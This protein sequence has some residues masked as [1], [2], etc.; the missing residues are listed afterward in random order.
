MAVATRVDAAT[1]YA[2]DVTEGRI[3]A[4]R[5]VRLACQRHLRDL[6]D[7]HLRG[8]HFDA[9]EAEWA[10]EFYERYLI[11]KDGQFSGRPFKLEPSQRFITGCIFGWK[12]ADGTRRFRMVYIEQGKGN[13]KTPWLA[14]T[15]LKLLVADRE[16]GAEIY[17][18]AVTR[19]QAGILFKDATEMVKRSPALSSKLTL[20]VGNIANPALGGFFRPV[21]HEAKSLDGKR[22][23]GGLIDELHEHQSGEAVDKIRMGTKARRQPLIIEITNSGF[24]TSSICWEHHDYSEKVLEGI[25]E[26]DEW[27]A[28]VCGLDVCDACRDKGIKFPTEGCEQCDDWRDESVWVKA[29][30]LLGVTIQ[31]DYL[32]AQVREADKM[33]G[34]KALTKRLCFC[35]WTEAKNPW[36]ST[37]LF[38]RGATPA[39]GPRLTQIP[40]DVRAVLNGRRCFGGLD[41][42]ST[43]DL[44]AFALVFPPK[45]D[46]PDGDWYVLVWHWLP[47][48]NMRARVDRDHVPYDVW[49]EE[50]WISLTPGN[51]I[52]YDFI[53]A[54]IEELAGEFEIVAVA[55]DPW[56]A[57]QIVQHLTED[58]LTMVE[59]RQ[60]FRSFTAPCD[61]ME[62]LVAAARLL[63]GGNPVLALAVAN[64]TVVR[65]PAGN[66]KP[67]KEDDKKRIDGLVATVMAIGEAIRAEPEEDE[68]FGGVDWI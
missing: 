59:C 50:G 15:G 34:K 43:Y 49:S 66:A 52:N 22:V 5:L 47:E 51:V 53:E 21:S 62:R 3:V 11:L 17:S 61:E 46:D 32:R 24:N 48:D 19:E 1:Q 10:F 58:G 38:S 26:D 55:Y 68:E 18:A 27:F 65:D 36:L 7:A 40:P 13:G 9:A 20:S 2:L 45:A 67:V 63:Y 35:I 39:Y 42:S 31:A 28:F 25:Y 60:G 37:E 4:G 6:E 8:L 16:S 44:S 30:P 41:L 29:N 12:R 64:A 54:Q 57:P 23:H 56:R 33:P 14:G